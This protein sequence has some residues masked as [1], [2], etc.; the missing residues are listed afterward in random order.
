VHETIHAA[1][2]NAATLNRWRSL[3]AVVGGNPPVAMPKGRLAE[4]VR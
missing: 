1:V 3:A 2:T 4:L